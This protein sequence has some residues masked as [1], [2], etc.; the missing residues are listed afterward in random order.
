[1]LIILPISFFAQEFEVSKSDRYKELFFSTYLDY[2]DSLS[3]KTTVF[4]KSF[5]E[6]R[7]YEGDS[8]EKPVRYYYDGW[9]H[10]DRFRVRFKF[11]IK[12]SHLPD[13]LKTLKCYKAGIVNHNNYRVFYDSLQN[14]DESMRRIKESNIEEYQKLSKIANRIEDYLETVLTIE[15]K[16]SIEKPENRIYLS[17][18][19]KGKS[20]RMYY[21]YSH[22]NVGRIVVKISHNDKRILTKQGYCVSEEMNEKIEEFVKS[23]ATTTVDGYSVVYDVFDN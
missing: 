6:S 8:L 2:K 3:S 13:N 21:I 22:K 10:F 20:K 4:G 1:M 19:K 5:H 9:S 7:S 11:K 15:R 23:L 18:I 14:L 12:K 16:E 17:Y